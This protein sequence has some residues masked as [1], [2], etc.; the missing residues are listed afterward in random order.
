MGGCRYHFRYQDIDRVN[1]D[2][3]E[4]DGNSGGL[5]FTRA[6]IHLFEDVN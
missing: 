5:D 6:P 1:G 2:N 4:N 3:K